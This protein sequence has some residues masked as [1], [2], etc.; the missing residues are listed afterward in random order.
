MLAPGERAKKLAL[1]QEFTCALLVD[2]AVRCWGRGNLLGLGTN[3]DHGDAPGPLPPPIELAGAALDLVAGHASACALIDG[4]EV[5]CW[6]FGG[7]GNHGRNDTESI[8]DEPGELVE[9]RFA[10]I[11][12]NPINP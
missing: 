11:Y 8:G 9:P 12:D 3:E 5:Q 7:A 4:G 6:G 10:L 2:G 1:A